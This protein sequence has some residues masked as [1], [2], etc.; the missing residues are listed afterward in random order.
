MPIS[1]E[2]HP[3]LLIDKDVDNDNPVGW[4]IR[5]LIGALKAGNCS[6]I[7]TAEGEHGKQLID[8]RA[9]ISCVLVGMR[10]VKE[11][12]DLIP[13][14]RDQ[15]P[16]FP[17]FIY[18]SISTMD[19]L[20]LEILGRI[21]GCFYKLEDTPTFISGRIREALRSYVSSLHPPFFK[22]LV[23][24]VRNSNFSWH[25][26]GHSG[27]MAYLKSPAGRLFFDFYG[28]TTF[29]A[30]LSVSVPALGSLLEH[31]GPVGD[32]E[33]RAAEIFG[34]DDTFYV[35]NGTSTANKI[36]FQS[37]LTR[38]DV[39][40]VDRNC[41][42]SVIHSIV[43]S[44]AR[45]IYLEPVRNRHGII[46]PIPLKE[47][48]PETIREKI[49]DSGIISDDDKKPLLAVVTNSTYDGLCYKS[50]TVQEA[51]KNE[52]SALHFDEA[53]YAYAKFHPL[54]EGRFGMSIDPD[55]SPL[56]FS[57]QSTHKL[58]A[59]FSQASMI[60]V[61]DNKSGLYD[62]H[63]FNETFQMNTSTSPQYSIIASL[64]MAAHMM[65]DEA[66]AALLRDAIQ[67]ALVFRILVERLSRFHKESEDWWFENWQPSAAVP[68]TVLQVI[69]C[70]NKDLGESP[71][72]EIQK[73]ERI[74]AGELVVDPD[75]WLLR[76][77]DSWH[78]F[79][80]IDDE[81]EIM[82]D[83][84]KVTILT[85]G[86]E[87][88]EREDYCG[89]GIP[90]RIVSRFLR[91]QGI[92]V[93]KTSLYSFLV[94]FTIGTTKG[95]AVTLLSALSRFKEHH[96]H[97]TPLSQIFPDLARD[98]ATAD[99]YASRGIKDLCEEMHKFLEDEDAVDIMF[100]LSEELPHARMPPGEAHEKL[101]R[102]EIE[103]LPRS[104]AAIGRI[105][106][107][108]IL[109]YPPAIPIIMP[110][111]AI[112]EKVIEY[113]GFLEDFDMAFPGFETEVHGVLLNEE[114][115]RKSKYSLYCVVDE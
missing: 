12:P 66:G 111:E 8:N 46:G 109:P 14:I 59:A 63:R 51:L 88:H 16:H 80:R 40:L 108:A 65:Q 22:Q 50:S 76:S 94:L 5:E 18:S 62:R 30:D 31:E 33:R 113:I 3:I 27:G 87:G 112:T 58:L 24:Y 85:P 89:P 60:H 9:E 7:K 4:A 92:A 43:T 96:D 114:E 74:H 44:G 93:E 67:E 83:P 26:P 41:H 36:I 64:D 115:D 77:E 45:P 10:L 25:T 38:G 56:I 95:K 37:M 48:A 72:E 47:F 102:N 68:K 86:M 29:R 107:T 28:E 103:I 34:A 91:E 52:I 97:N 1:F 2:D 21:D 17:I 6:V 106:A 99:R 70:I 75:D 11:D 98:P 81:A 73:L 79:D 55:E 53:W 105:S 39:V 71:R 61:K 54:Y 84:V 110:G 19:H 13:F 20:P 42:V 23:S 100:R 90:G 101:I 15:N 32:S 82:L 78:G 57:S 49:K 104:R 69:S 35:T